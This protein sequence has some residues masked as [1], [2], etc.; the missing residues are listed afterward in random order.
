MGNYCYIIE[1]R[2]FSTSTEN[3]FHTKEN[4]P[5]RYD[6]VKVENGFNR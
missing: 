5:F 4:F 6:A 2:P 3:D 1:K